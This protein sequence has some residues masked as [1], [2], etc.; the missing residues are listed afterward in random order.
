MMKSGRE[1]RERERVEWTVDAYGRAD[2]LSQ[3]AAPHQP[4]PAAANSGTMSGSGSLGS[5]VFACG[6]SHAYISEQKLF[7]LI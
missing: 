1:W 2:I 6:A 3:S 5:Q 4:A 7:Y